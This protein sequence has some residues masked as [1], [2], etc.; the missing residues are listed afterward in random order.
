LD[1]FILKV[2]KVNGLHLR[3]L[4]FA[5]GL[6]LAAILLAFLPSC[7][8]GQQCTLPELHDQSF[9]IEE[10]GYVVFF[11]PNTGE[12]S[13]YN[14]VVKPS[15]G[16]IVSTGEDGRDS[17]YLPDSDYFGNDQFVYKVCNAKECTEDIHVNITIKSI[18]DVPIVRNKNYHIKIGESVHV[19]YGSSFDPDGADEALKYKI[20]SEPNHGTFQDFTY[21]PNP[22]FRGLDTVKYSVTDAQGGVGYGTFY[23]N[24]GISAPMILKWH[25]KKQADFTKPH[26]HI[27]TSDR[28]V[29]DYHVDWGDGT[30][31]T[32]LSSDCNHT[33][34]H[35]GE[36]SIQIWGKYPHLYFW[37][38]DL[39]YGFGYTLSLS[40]LFGLEQWGD[41]EWKSTENL[42]SGWYKMWILSS[43]Q[44]DMSH[45]VSA[46][47]MFEGV[48]HFNEP[49]N[50]WDVSRIE[51]FSGMFSGTAFDQP[52]DKWNTSHAKNMA[53]MFDRTPFNHSLNQWDVSHV[54]NME[55]MFLGSSYNQP[56][57]RWD[58]S[59]VTCMAKMFAVS[60]FNQP[61]NS[62]DVSNVKDMRGMFSQSQFNQPLN[63]WDVS[64]VTNMSSMFEDSIFNHPISSWDVS[65]VKEMDFM[66]YGSK[67]FNQNLS[68]W[69]LASATSMAHMFANTEAFQQDLSWKTPAGPYVWGLF[70]D[71]C[72]NGKLNGWDVSSIDDMENMFRD[73][74]CF[75]QPLD[76]WDVHNVTSMDGMFWGAK[77]FDQDL[78]NWDITG[79]RFYSNI[80]NRN[81]GMENAFKGTALSTSNYDL[82]LQQWAKLHPGKNIVLDVGH[83]QYSSGAK[84]ARNIL[85]N[86]FQWK[87][88]DGGEK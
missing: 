47:R 43:D 53:A 25:V 15:H 38:Q 55:D 61:L 44:P 21:T 4:R 79:L 57:D 11:A 49:V 83:T 34:T 22:D 27:K 51:D 19:T 24:V 28:F 63:S 88:H 72:Y 32:Q 74:R 10:D 39:F 33:F 3:N 81:G 7:G 6:A 84:E 46:S 8:G 16:R 76:Q 60:Q 62:W 20:V 52:V 58:V 80:N 13:Y 26:I 56:L 40:G 9:S 68:N 82:M 35:P 31:S 50:N 2:L 86:N 54:V 12:C 42:F 65:S 18:N 37:G 66:F 77:H 67:R 78:S 30:K 29:Y 17:M 70:E 48:M 23:F 5:F 71:S 69:R 45:V 59:N 87:I 14:K 41:M 64:S 73:N 36:Y 1:K 75:N 85:I